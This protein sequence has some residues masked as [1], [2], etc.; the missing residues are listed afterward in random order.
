MV[1]FVI[2]GVQKSGT[3]ALASFLSQ[4]PDCYIPPIKEVHLFDAEDWGGDESVE[5]IN[6]RY[7][8]AFEDFNAQRTVGDATPIYI[9]M[10]EV[11]SAIYK[12]NPHI[13]IILLLRDPVERAISHYRMEK[14]RGNEALPLFL[15]ILL[16]PF[17][18]IACKGSRR[19]SSARRLHSYADRSRYTSQLKN[20]FLHF[21]KNQVLLL[22]TQELR[23]DHQSTLSRVF[24][25]LSIPDFS[26]RILPEIVFSN[27][28]RPN[29]YIFSRALLKILL[30]KEVRYFNS[31]L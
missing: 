7:E 26:N 18:L 29:R 12:Y 2:A 21:P 8:R 16:E 1:N 30:R 4:H 24:A 19:Q 28:G 11:I 20:L 17:R 23:E 10:P 9:Y 13:K 22:K 5:E 3:S 25:F 6:A 27:E 31:V 14:N 15:A